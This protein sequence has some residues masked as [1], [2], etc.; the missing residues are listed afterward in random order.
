MAAG[1]NG[2]VPDVWYQILH[3]SFALDKYGNFTVPSLAY[4]SRLRV[5]C[6][7]L[8]EANSLL[9]TP[10][11]ALV[12]Y[13]DDRKVVPIR[14]SGGMHFGSSENYQALSIIRDKATGRMFAVLR[15]RNLVFKGG[16]FY[17]SVDRTYSLARLAELLNGHSPDWS[18]RLP[19][20][21]EMAYRSTSS[22]LTYRVKQPTIFERAG[23]KGVV[24]KNQLVAKEHK[25]GPAA[26]TN[27]H[28]DD[29]ISHKVFEWRRPTPPPPVWGAQVARARVEYY[30]HHELVL[31]TS[32]DGQ[33]VKARE[34]AWGSAW[35][36]TIGTVLQPY[37]FHRPLQADGQPFFAD[38][39][40][41]LAKALGWD[42]APEIVKGLGGLASLL[43]HGMGPSMPKSLDDAGLAYGIP[44]TVTVR[45][46][47]MACAARELCADEEAE[48]AHLQAQMEKLSPS[49]PKKRE[50]RGAATAAEQA[51]AASA[52]DAVNLDGSVRKGF[53]LQWS[54]RDRVADRVSNE[55]AIREQKKAGGAE[56]W[57]RKREQERGD[58]SWEPEKKRKPRSR[59]RTPTPTPTPDAIDPRDAAVNDCLRIIN[60][61]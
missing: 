6:T 24:T 53:A 20:V 51:L 10:Y 14:F 39:V 52:M 31:I 27:Y 7:S 55:N 44:K 5:V 22:V 21:H 43:A 15:T 17:C 25:G 59:S 29:C 33:P 34:L 30:K 61:L 23:I 28:L 36:G 2:A 57:H 16:V 38:H 45:L 37:D 48:N 46:E 60:S 35:I 32:V 13:Q 11:D 47:R 42:C 8:R 54:R 50:R 58:D 1:A 4:M 26:G 40:H 3:S 49:A 41:V 56:A 18:T 12:D 9:E 19:D